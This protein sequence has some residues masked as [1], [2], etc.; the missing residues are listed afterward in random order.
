MS[1]FLHLQIAKP[2][3]LLILNVNG[4][5]SYFPHSVVQHGNAQIFGRNIDRSKVEVKI[6]VEHFLS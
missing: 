1:S 6:G 5:L 4:L 2:E 3:K